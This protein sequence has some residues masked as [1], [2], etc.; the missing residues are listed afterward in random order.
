MTGL[1]TPFVGGLWKTVGLQTTRV[2]E[3]FK[4]S[5]MDQPTGSM[6]GISAVSNVN[7]G[8]QL[9]SCQGAGILVASIKTF[10]RIF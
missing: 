6:E 9:K 2:A 8:M 7:C 5:L 4:W 3:H 10:L 1:T